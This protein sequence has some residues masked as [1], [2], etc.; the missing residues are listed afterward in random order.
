MMMSMVA[1]HS[2]ALPRA[3]AKKWALSAGENRPT[4]SAM[5]STM[6]TLARSS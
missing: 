6:E 5:F 3:M 2:A 4:A 1:A